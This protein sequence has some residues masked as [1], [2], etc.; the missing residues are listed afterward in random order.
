MK[1]QINVYSCIIYFLLITF[2]NATPHT[3]QTS[4]PLPRRFQ[5]PNGIALGPDGSLFIGSVTEGHI[6]RRRPNGRF[7]TFFRGHPKVFAGTSLRVDHTRGWLWGASPDFL[8]TRRK[9]GSLHRRPHRIFA[10]SLKDATL[11]R[12]IYLPKGGF[13]NDIAISPRGDVFITDSKLGCIW[14]VHNNAT[15]LKRWFRAPQLQ[16]G[17][18]GPAGIA[19]FPNGDLL[20]GLFSVGKLYRISKKHKH[21]KRLFPSV[22]I[23]NADGLRV[24]PDRSIVVLDANIGR[25]G[26]VILLRK[27]KT[28]H[29]LAQGLKDPVNLTYNPQSG[30]LW[31][32]TCDIR[33]LMKPKQHKRVPKQF[34][35]HRVLSPR[36]KKRPSA[37]K[38]LRLPKAFYPESIAMAADGTIFTGSATRSTILTLTKNTPPTRWLDGTKMGLMSVQ[39]L[40]VHEPTQRLFVCTGDLKVAKIKD[41]PSALFAF[42]LRTKRKRG[43]WTLPSGGF[44]NDLTQDGHG[45]LL[46][47]DTSKARILRLSLQ[48]KKPQLKTWLT[49]PLLGGSAY[50]GNGIAYD[51]STQSIYLNTFADG[52]LLQIT[53]NRTGHPKHV[54]SLKLPRRLDG[55]DGMRVMGAG[56]LLI[57]ENGLIKGNGRITEASIHGQKVTLRTLHTATTQ[58]TSGLF[59]G[60]ELLYLRSHF[61]EVFGKQKTRTPRAAAIV[62]QPLP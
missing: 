61:S 8:G 3:T 9:D 56:R 2:A 24:L 58:P 36:W 33:R 41:R 51:H 22:N 26:R 46:I 38:T 28:P 54:R 47:S 6:I 11:Q 31:V 25:S 14:K 23:K 60:T 4:F 57:F 19:L 52:R 34:Y 30:A 18:L 32:T 29:I 62:I 44:C 27:G 16:R 10:I 50:N 55:A 21:I 13:G 37:V 42:D 35:I 45:G 48:S 5:L 12:V 49:H 7:E 43:Y 15:T 59:T 1:I 39:G 20:V 40:L 17:K 53:M